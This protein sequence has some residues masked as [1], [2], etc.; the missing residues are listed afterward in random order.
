M[1]LKNIIEKC[2]TF[3]VF[4]AAIID[5]EEI[6]FDKNLRTYCEANSCGCF[7]KNYACPPSIGDVDS[8]ISEAKSY[9]TALVFQTVHQIEDS[10][11]F[12]GMTEA[13]AKHSKAAEALDAEIN[14]EY[15]GYLKLTAGACN[16]CTVCSQIENKPCRFPDKAVSSLEAYCMD[17]TV[18]AKVCGMKYINGQNTVTYFGVFLF[19]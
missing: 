19:Q 8:V 1:T 15:S 14:K 10:F 17:V 6:P 12:E 3:G 11:D 4:K 7:G 16:I 9:R 13:V 5:V 18:L 2:E